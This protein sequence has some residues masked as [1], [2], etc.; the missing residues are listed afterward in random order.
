MVQ[1]ILHQVSTRISQ[2]VTWLRG[3]EETGEIPI[4]C[5]AFDTRSNLKEAGVL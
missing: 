5:I 3:Y 2:V 4:D 1:K